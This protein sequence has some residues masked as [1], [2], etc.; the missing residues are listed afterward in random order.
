MTIVPNS[1]SGNLEVFEVPSGCRLL[2]PFDPTAM[3]WGEVHRLSALAMNAGLGGSDPVE[4]A[5]HE[6]SDVITDI[7]IDG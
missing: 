2:I 7:A 5:Y 1:A 3:T 4:F 6:G